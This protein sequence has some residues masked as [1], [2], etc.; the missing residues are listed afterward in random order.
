M[1][2]LAQA[3]CESVRDHANS[4]RPHRLWDTDLARGRGSLSIRT[5]RNR[6]RGELHVHEVCGTRQTRLG[7]EALRQRVQGEGIVSFARRDAPESGEY[8]R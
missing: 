4:A 8:S 1:A 2:N 6:T 7:C 5:S 3:L